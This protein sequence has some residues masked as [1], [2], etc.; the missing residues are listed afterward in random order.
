MIRYNKRIFLHIVSSSVLLSNSIVVN[1]TIRGRLGI[2]T[3]ISVVSNS[4][5]KKSS[6]KFGTI[7]KLFATQDSQL[8]PHNQVAEVINKFNDD[9][10]SFLSTLIQ[11]SW[12][13]P[14]RDGMDLVEEKRIMLNGYYYIKDGDEYFPIVTSGDST[15]KFDIPKGIITPKGFKGKESKNDDLYDVKV[16]ETR[17]HMKFDLSDVGRH[18]KKIDTFEENLPEL[19][20]SDRIGRYNPLERE[21]LSLAYGYTNEILKLKSG[22]GKFF[23]EQRDKDRRNMLTVFMANFSNGDDPEFNKWLNGKYEALKDKGVE[24]KKLRDK[25]ISKSEATGVEEGVNKLSLKLSGSDVEGASGGSDERYEKQGARPKTKLI[26]R[27]QQSLESSGNDL[28]RIKDTSKDHSEEGK[29]FKID[30]SDMRKSIKIT[31]KIGDDDSE[32]EEATEYGIGYLKVAG[33][34]NYE[35]KIIYIQKSTLGSLNF[36]EYFIV[37]GGEKKKVVPAAPGSQIYNYVLDGGG[38]EIFD[39]IERSII[40]NAIN[41]DGEKKKV[42]PQRLTLDDGTEK[43]VAYQVENGLW[44]EV[45]LSSDGNY[46]LGSVLKYEKLGSKVVGKLRKVGKIYKR[47]LAP[48]TSGAAAVGKGVSG[49]ID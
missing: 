38:S 48:L 9:K 19:S 7:K 20:L 5:T 13:I 28:T 6:S 43:T 15:R 47:Y 46:Y 21:F 12:K 1:A 8:S 25:L 29:K 44:R 2:S 49:F 16:V 3:A 10:K 36:D 18:T 26:T 37:Q 35:Q 27:P 17:E 4:L 34:D 33:M 39:K 40:V 32:K 45:V 31:S 11:T 41:R 23:P 42:I 30:R 24:L 14:L 22:D